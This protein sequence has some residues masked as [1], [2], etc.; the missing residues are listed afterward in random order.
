MTCF[1]KL[2]V[3]N[4]IEAIR[5]RASHASSGFT[6]RDPGTQRTKFTK[7]NA[8]YNS[9]LCLMHKIGT[10]KICVKVFRTGF[11]ITGSD[12]FERVSQTV[13]MLDLAPEHVETVAIQMINLLVARGSAVDLDEVC[14]KLA[15]QGT[16]LQCLYDPES[17]CGL[18]IKVPKRHDQLKKSTVLLFP[19]GKQI[20]TGV[21]TGED[22][23][24]VVERIIQRI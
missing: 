11:H 12:S 7:V 3:D 24:N 23:D 16:G 20:I 13:G 18:R 8:F 22:I 5:K 9:P 15:A 10:R 17:Y 21:T 14:G 4:D 2:S 19:S 6:V 1:V